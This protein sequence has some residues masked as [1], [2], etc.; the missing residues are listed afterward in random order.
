MNKKQIIFFVA[1]VIILVMVNDADAQ[2]AMCRKNLESNLQAGK[3]IGRNINKGI[4]Y[5][6]TVPYLAIGFIFRKQ[7]YSF[8]KSWRRKKA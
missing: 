1:V 7:I 3:G 8:Y 2:C 6:M 5:L 4:L